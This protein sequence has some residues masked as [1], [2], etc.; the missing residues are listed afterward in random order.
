MEPTTFTKC[1][2]YIFIELQGNSGHG[3]EGTAV[4]LLHDIPVAKLLRLLPGCSEYLNLATSFL[5]SAFSK[6]NW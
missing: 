6:D 1:S 3:N 4:R 5:R 2:K